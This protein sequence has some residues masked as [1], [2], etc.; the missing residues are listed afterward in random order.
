MHIS[1]LEKAIARPP[2]TSAPSLPSID[3]HPGFA[4]VFQHEQL[5]IGLVKAATEHWR[6][7]RETGA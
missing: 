1:D 3:D 2:I 7:Q 5:T 4:V 6:R